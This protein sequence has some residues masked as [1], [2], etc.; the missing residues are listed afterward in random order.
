[1]FLLKLAT[2]NLFRNVRRSLLTILT[3][4]IGILSLVAA[5]GLVRGVEKSFTDANIN[6]DTGHLRVFGK[7]YLKD[8]ESLPLDIVV[9]QPKKVTTLLKKTFPKAIVFERIIF[10]AKVSDGVHGLNVRGVVMPGASS[11]KAFHYTKKSQTKKPMP[12]KPGIAVIGCQLAKTFKKK[13]GDT[14]TVEARTQT[15]SLNAVD[16]KIHDVLCTGHQL[17]DGFSLF[18]P[19][20]TGRAFLQ[21]PKDVTDIVVR[22]QHRGQSLKAEAMLK[23]QTPKNRPLTWQE[24]AQEIIQLNGPRRKMFNGLLAL[25]FLLAAAGLANTVVMG[26]YERKGEI[27]MMLAMGLER[28]KIVVLFALE[29]AMMGFVGGLVGSVLGGSLSWYY[30]IHGIDISSSAN[31]IG[32]SSTGFSYV[33]FLYFDFRPEMMLIG[34]IVGVVIAILAAVWPATRITRLEPREILAGR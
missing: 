28:T 27:G 17:V 26:G 2:R 29:A 30:S 19:V 20:A 23:K 31:A 10:S 22:F 4:V 9:S 7:G 11:Y 5:T 21:M 34:T 16:V 12:N 1:M 24:K 6:N 25:L 8:E 3:V 18:M 33:N 13:I 32:G 14:L 15:G